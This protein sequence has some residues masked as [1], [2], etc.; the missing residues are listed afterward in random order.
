MRASAGEALSKVRRILPSPCVVKEKK[1][2]P[3]LPRTKGNDSMVGAGTTSRSNAVRLFNLCGT[4]KDELPSDAAARPWATSKA[5]A[6]KIRIF[7]GIRA[8]VVERFHGILSG[9]GELAISTDAVPDLFLDPR[10]R[11]ASFCF[12]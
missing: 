1:I 12:Q 7:F 10:A 2:Q 6:A 3:S 4:A 8:R 5:A 11:A 9:P